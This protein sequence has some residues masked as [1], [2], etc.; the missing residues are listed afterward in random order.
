MAE[1]TRNLYGVTRERAKE[2]R[3]LPCDICG[4]NSKS[5]HIDHN[6]KHP[7]TYRGV[8]C[9]T[10]NTFVGYLEKNEDKLD[11]ALEY[12]STKESIRELPD[13]TDEIKGWF[14]RKD[15]S[16]VRPYAVERKFKG[17][18][19]FKNCATECGAIMAFKTALLMERVTYAR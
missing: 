19:F 1:S 8:L 18:R 11:K 7:K 4:D 5:N 9:R 10:C 17:A 2:L 15:K 16:R 12:I 13:Y 14:L 3:S 6:H